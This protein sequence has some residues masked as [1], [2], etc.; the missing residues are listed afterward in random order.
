MGR[1]ML[2]HEVRSFG[3]VCINGL[4]LRGEYLAVDVTMCR[5]CRLPNLLLIACISRTMTKSTLP[6]NA[7]HAISR[8]CSLI[9]ANESSLMPSCDA[10]RIGCFSGDSRCERLKL[11]RF[12]RSR[13]KALI[14]FMQPH[15]LLDARTT[16]SAF[17]EVLSRDAD[18]ITNPCALIS[19]YHAHSVLYQVYKKLTIDSTKSASQA[20][21]L[22]AAAISPTTCKSL[23]PSSSPMRR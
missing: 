14:L 4:E 22:L 13:H 3:E 7:F 8:C 12:D 2:L 6:L 21:I 16:E 5:V 23:G 20:S 17:A 11:K 10:M 18:R 9:F 19:A 1:L 15:A